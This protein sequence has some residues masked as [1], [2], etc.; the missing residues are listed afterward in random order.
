MS[1][2]LI[3]YHVSPKLQGTKRNGE[4]DTQM[5]HMPFDCNDLDGGSA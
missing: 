4:R 2:K 1:E 5:Q 3:A